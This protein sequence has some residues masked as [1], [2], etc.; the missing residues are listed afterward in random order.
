MRL[1]RWFARYAL[2]QVKNRSRG[3][4]RC[5]SLGGCGAAHVGGLG[6]EVVPP[7]WNFYEIPVADVR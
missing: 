6:Y 2:S 3:I 1:N 7:G 5:C 4:W